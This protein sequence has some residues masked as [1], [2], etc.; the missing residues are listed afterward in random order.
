MQN[1]AS[2]LEYNATLAR[3]VVLSA[4]QFKRRRVFGMLRDLVRF[5]R[6]GVRSCWRPEDE[7]TLGDYLKAHAVDGN[8]WCRWRPRCGPFAAR[9][10]SRSRCAICAIHGQNHC[11]LQIT[12]RPD[13]RVVC[14]GSLALL[15]RSARWQRPV[16]NA[17]VLRVRRNVESVEIETA[18][19]R[20]LRQRGSFLPRRRCI[21]A[22]HRRRHERE[23]ASSVYDL[24]YQ[25]NDTVL[26]TDTTLLPR[27]QG[28]GSMERAHIPRES[29]A[30]PATVSYCMNLLQGVDGPERTSLRS[31][32]PSTS[33]RAELRRMNYRHPYNAAEL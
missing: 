22:A 32:E 11:M 10:F 20:E 17:P 15:R 33:S 4:T 6:I 16:L 23:R 21:G 26:H 28:L 5:Y 30:K 2:G 12:G 24:S 18:A 29:G 9:A 7:Q 27:A 13:W 19:G 8:T 3:C 1:A 25:T 14:G 31:I